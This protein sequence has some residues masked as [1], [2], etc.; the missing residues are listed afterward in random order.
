[1]VPDHR[2]VHAPAVAWLRTGV[3]CPRAVPGPVSELHG[4]WGLVFWG[5]IHEVN[6]F[7][8]RWRFTLR[9]CL[10]AA[11]HPIRARYCEALVDGRCLVLVRANP[12]DPDLH[13]G[14]SGPAG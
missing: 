10:R 12:A 1:L 4:S 8:G 5:W 13:R 14:A 2:L 6:V 9:A 3:G 11:R 7:L